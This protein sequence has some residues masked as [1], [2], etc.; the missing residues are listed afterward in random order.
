MMGTR[1]LAG[2]SLGIA[3]ALAG[4]G[5]ARAAVQ[6]GSAQGRDGERRGDRLARYLGL[7]EQQQ[8]SWK[9]LHE[10][11]Q[12]DMQPMREEG[13]DLHQKLKAAMES[14][15]PD[16][17][18]VGSAMLALKQHREKMMTAEKAFRGQL[19]ALLTPD[20]KTKFEALGAA[21]G[22]GRGRW[23][24]RGGHRPGGVG[25]KGGPDQTPESTPDGVV[26]G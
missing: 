7:N 22:F 26:E 13:R 8:A 5:I 24:G 20:Q 11:H 18:A 23:G 15:N 4:A 9:S 12:T 2:L 3:L 25:P 16:P 14:S 19:E 21:H 17:A 1:G 10:Q 6:D